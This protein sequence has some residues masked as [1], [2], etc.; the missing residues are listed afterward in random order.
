VARS[1]W[2]LAHGDLDVVRVTRAAFAGQWAAVRDARTLDD[3]M[4]P[5][6]PDLRRRSDACA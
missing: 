2:A 3:A 1:C 4:V 5:C 6:I